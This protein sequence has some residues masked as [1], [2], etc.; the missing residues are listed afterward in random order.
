MAFNISFNQTSLAPISMD[1]NSIIVNVKPLAL[2][3]AGIVIYAIFIFKF[4]KYLSKRDILTA[5]WTHK[6]SWNEGHIKSIIKVFLYILE[7]IILVPIIIFFWFLVMALLLLFMS[8]N[9]ANHIMLIS[10]A[11][12]AAIRVVAYY[13]ED[14]A[15]DLAKLMPLTLIAI[16]VSDISFFSLSTTF[17]NAKNMFSILDKLVFYLMFA[18]AVEFIMRIIELIREAIKRNEGISRS[19]D[20]KLQ[21]QVRK[22]KLE[23]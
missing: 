3:V 21:Q 8:N 6:Y 12:V 13:R 4:Y 5:G 20:K 14:L 17:E 9:S 1:V 2:M 11:I 16:F 15:I 10:M 22:I 18:V 23:E 7:Y 19:N